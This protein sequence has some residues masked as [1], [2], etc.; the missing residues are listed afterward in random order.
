MPQSEHKCWRAMKDRFRG[1]SLRV[2]R[3]QKS[4]QHRGDFPAQLDSHRW[5]RSSH[6]FQRLWVRRIA[7]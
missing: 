5:R 2:C 1:F 6:R 7:W 4:H 3:S